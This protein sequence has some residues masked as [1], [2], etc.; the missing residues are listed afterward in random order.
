MT[1]A[2]KVKFAPKTG[3]QVE[4]FEVDRKSLKA[5]KTGSSTPVLA[6]G[7]AVEHIVSVDGDSRGDLIIGARLADSDRRR[8][9]REALAL[10]RFASTTDADTLSAIGDSTAT[11]T[12]TGTTMLLDECHFAYLGQPY[13][14]A[15]DG[16]VFQPVADENGYSILVHVFA[17]DETPVE[18][19]EVLP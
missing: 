5:K 14:V 3:L 1:R 13:V 4:S 8:D 18:A 12:G 7:S 11:G 10:T 6:S 9:G 15:P 17:G 16:R 19:E 2:A